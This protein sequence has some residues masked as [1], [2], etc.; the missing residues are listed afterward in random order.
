MKVGQTLKIR[1]IGT[2]NNFIHPMRVHGGP[3]E[4]VA[5]HGETLSPAA[6]YLAD[7]VNVGPGQ[8]YDVIWSARRS[9]KWLIHC[10]IPHHTTNN[11]AEQQGG[12][13]LTAI[14]DVAP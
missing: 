9:G 4:V 3:F 2:A 1:F 12:G 5:R 8:R 14:I 6:R 10:H 13:G 7:T 11:N